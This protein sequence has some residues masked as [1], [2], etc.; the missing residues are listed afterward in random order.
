MSGRRLRMN[1]IKNGW[2]TEMM[3]S[4]GG[5]EKQCTWVLGESRFA[6]PLTN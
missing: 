1:L 5:P 3:N 6:S 2:M 4:A